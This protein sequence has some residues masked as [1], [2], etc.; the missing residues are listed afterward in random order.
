M[1]PTR[2]KARKETKIQE[3]MYGNTVNVEYEIHDFIGNN[4]SNRNGNK[5][6]N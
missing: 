3:F 1:S 4:W 5:V 2:K 6:L